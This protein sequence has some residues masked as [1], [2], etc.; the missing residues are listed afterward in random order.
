MLYSAQAAVQDT[1]KQI[2]AQIAEAETKESHVPDPEGVTACTTHMDAR[3][4]QKQKKAKDGTKGIPDICQACND[5]AFCRPILKE[6]WGRHLPLKLYNSELDKKINEPQVTAKLLAHNCKRTSN[7]KQIRQ[8][9]L[10]TMYEVG[11]TSTPTSEVRSSPVRARLRD[12]AR[13]K[14]APGAYT[15]EC[16]DFPQHHIQKLAAL[17]EML[18]IPTN[19]DHKCAIPVTID[20]LKKKSILLE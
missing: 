18:L 13:E 14:L 19:G 2:N 10:E 17:N 4:T 11:P 7:A 5:C 15:R 6:C 20:D 8:L 12:A 9:I 1:L 16:S 3:N